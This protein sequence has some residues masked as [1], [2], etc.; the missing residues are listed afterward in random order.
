MLTDVEKKILVALQGDITIHPAPYAALAE[1]IGISEETFLET[2]KSLCDRNI[3][4]RFGATLRHQKSGFSANAMGAWIVPEDRVEEVGILMA[5]KPEV[6]HCYRRNPTND[7]PYNVYTMIHANSKEGCF[8]TA[9][10]LSE[11]TGITNYKLLF[12]QKELKKTSM[13]Y[14][15][16]EDD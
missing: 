3:I 14:F 15:S 10:K 9:Q 12:S 11:E 16:D 13:S 4:R 1:N 2:L 8:K 6:T 5:Q 7:F